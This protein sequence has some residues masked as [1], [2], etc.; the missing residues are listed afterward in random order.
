MYKNNIDDFIVFI[1]GLTNFKYVIQ[2][3]YIYVKTYKIICHVFQNT[4]Y[5]I[6]KY[7]YLKLLSI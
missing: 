1:D 7:K 3:C 5:V 2:V 6:R 4:Y